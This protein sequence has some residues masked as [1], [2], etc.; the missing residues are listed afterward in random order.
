M[1]NIYARYWSIRQFNQTQR[2]APQVVC[3]SIENR[4][5]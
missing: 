5:S 4:G 2:I 3:E 1:A